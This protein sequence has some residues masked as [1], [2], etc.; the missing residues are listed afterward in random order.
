MKIRAVSDVIDEFKL[1]NSTKK[2]RFDKLC[3]EHEGLQKIREKICEL[4]LHNMQCALNGE[5]YE[6]QERALKL[7]AAEEKTVLEEIEKDRYNC[8]E[9]ED[10][11]RL[12]AKYCNC[13]LRKIYKEYYNAVDI[14]NSNIDYS[15]FSLDMF[16]NT[17]IVK[18]NKTQYGFMENNLR[19]AKKHIAAYPN[20]QRKNL[21]LTG[22]AGLGK[23]FLL[24]CMAKDAYE[25][26]IDVMLIRANEMFS[27]FFSHRMGEGADLSFLYNADMLMIDD[28]GTEPITQNVSIEYLYELID[29]RLVNNKHTIFS[30]NIE[31]LQKRYDERI[32][33]RIE[34]KTDGITMLFDGG[35]LRT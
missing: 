18:Y 21:L 10:T 4:A 34:S 2:F 5:N 14:K 6:E 16:D 28:L 17:K 3:D 22:K 15:K 9:C 23:S 19:I 13:L 33:S 27:M 31:N 1:Y 12:G 29:R 8:A 32:S 20:T 11:G 7:L 35:D 26:G 30:T 24:Y 25:R